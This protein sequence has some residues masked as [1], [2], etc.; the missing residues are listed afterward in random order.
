MDV[1][2]GFFQKI[3]KSRRNFLWAQS[4]KGIQYCPAYFYIIDVVWYFIDSTK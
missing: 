1:K 2:V 3:K 4:P